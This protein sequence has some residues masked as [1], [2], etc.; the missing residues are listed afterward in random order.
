[1]DLVSSSDP[2]RPRLDVLLFALQSRVRMMERS[3]TSTAD[4]PDRVHLPADIPFEKKWDV[5]KPTI[6]RLYID[7]S[8]GLADVM[9]IIGTEFGFVAL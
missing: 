4:N 3:T 2:S 7:E 8:R 5:L 6:K 9:D 1:M